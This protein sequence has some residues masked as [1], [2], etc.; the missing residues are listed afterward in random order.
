MLHRRIIYSGIKPI[1]ESAVNI[2]I[3]KLTEAFA[4]RH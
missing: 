2:V 3:T 4:L 1:I